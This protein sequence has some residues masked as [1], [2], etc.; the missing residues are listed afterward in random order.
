LASGETS[1][2]FAG[3][4]LVVLVPKGNPAGIHGPADLAKAVRLAT[5]D[6]AVAPQGQ[7]AQEWLTGL[8]LWKTLFPKF[9]F[10]ANAA[11][12]DEY[13]ARG[14]VDAGI[15][16][17]SDSHGRTDLQIAYM[18]PAGAIKPIRYVGVVISS[19]ARAAI[20]RAYVDQLLSSSVQAS[21][22]SAGFQP[23]PAR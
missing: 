11:Q 2:T 23:A 19:S 3:N 8:G 20:A 17:A 21:F 4:T 13:V 15:G 22:V 10:A 18:V 1:T 14:E 12:T 9:V 5:G 7:K 16:F 6:P